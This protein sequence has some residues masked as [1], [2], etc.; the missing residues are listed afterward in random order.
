MEDAEIIELFFRRSEQALR[1]LDAKY[2]KACHALA[3]SIT[4]S[5]EDAE[6]CV[7]DAYLGAW[8]AIPPARPDPLRAYVLRI[9]RN[10]SL[11]RLSQRGAARRG[12]A[13]AEALQ[14]LEGVLSAPDTAETALEAKE[15]VRLMEGFLDTL[16]REN[17]VIFLRRYWFG[18]PYAEIARRTGISEK[19]VSVRL[20]RM[21]RQLKEYLRKKGGYL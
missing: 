1:E 12:G 18:D 5:P 21:R 7:S 11:K 9:V 13:Y 2:G 16:R 8:N 10:L 20:T 14:E 17:R 3:R 15:L 19:N 6:E 4:G